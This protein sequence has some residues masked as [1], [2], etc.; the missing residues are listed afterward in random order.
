MV[1][2]KTIFCGVFFVRTEHCISPQHVLAVQYCLVVLK[3][4]VLCSFF[5]VIGFRYDS[6]S[7]FNITN[8]EKKHER[9][10]LQRHFICVKACG[11]TSVHV[12]VGRALILRNWG[13]SLLTQGL[14][15]L[16]SS[17]FDNRSHSPAT[18]VSLDISSPSS[19]CEYLTNA[20]SITF[21]FLTASINVLPI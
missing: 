14:I 4:Y 18:E 1:L 6:R 21:Y 7:L 19:F 11:W 20:L 5:V 17:T 3:L 2:G 12:L 10:K 15:D 8:L 9:T 13:A 16:L